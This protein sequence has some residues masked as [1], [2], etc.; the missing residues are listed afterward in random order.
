MESPH[1]YRGKE[2]GEAFFKY[3][4]TTITGNYAWQQRTLQLLYTLQTPITK[5][6]L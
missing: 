6:I 4:Y 2:E 5:A 1:Q 3:A